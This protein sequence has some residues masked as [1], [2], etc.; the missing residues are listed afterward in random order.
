LSVLASQWF[1]QLGV[2]VF[3]TRS[4]DTQAPD[5]TDY[6][7]SIF[8]AGTRLLLILNNTTTLYIYI[9]LYYG[10]EF[11]S[12]ITSASGSVALAIICIVA[13]ALA[14]PTS[15]MRWI[16][17]TIVQGILMITFSVFA[18]SRTYVQVKSRQLQI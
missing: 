13:V 15:N 6:R 1:I 18:L 2:A 3:M 17:L 9:Y 7:V 14:G 5:H 11:L 10:V 8:I 12:L 4:T 16:G